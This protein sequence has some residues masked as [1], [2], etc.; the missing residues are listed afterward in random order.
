MHVIKNLP[1][2]VVFV[3]VDF[4]AIILFPQS[5]V[6][7]PVERVI[8]AESLRLLDF[9][10]THIGDFYLLLAKS[11]IIERLIRLGDTF[12]L[13]DSSATP[14][15]SQLLNLW[16]VR[17]W[18]HALLTSHHVLGNSHDFTVEISMIERR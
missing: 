18:Q 8:S 11:Q 12:R 1:G 15:S 3:N 13:H 4:F 6:S 9:Y 2:N 17:P 14:V 7:N 10:S 16:K 5:G